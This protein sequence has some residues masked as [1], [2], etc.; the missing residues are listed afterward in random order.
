MQVLNREET[1]ERLQKQQREVSGTATQREGAL[2][3]LEVQLLAAREEKRRSQEE[4]GTGQ[5]DENSQR[6]SVLCM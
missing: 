2:Q 1:I 5:R 6:C 3:K 4:V